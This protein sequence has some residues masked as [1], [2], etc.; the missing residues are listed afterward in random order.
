MFELLL[1]AVNA[2]Q[3]VVYYVFLLSWKT[4]KFLTT[5]GK[6][7]L[8]CLSAALHYL[9][10]TMMVFLEDF[11]P[12]ASDILRYLQATVE[13]LS[14]FKNGLF[15]IFY[16][17]HSILSTIVNGLVLSIVQ[18]F[19]EVI[20]VVFSVLNGIIEVF[21]FIKR[22]LILFGAGVWFLLT[23]IPLFVVSC[24]IYS[25]YCVGLLIEE[26]KNIITK[27][28]NKLTHI[29][30]FVT[31]VPLES[32]AGLL[33]AICLVYIFVKFHVEMYDF[34]RRKFKMFIIVA[35]RNIV[36]INWRFYKRNADEREEMVIEE[37][38]CIIC[39]ENVKDVL[40]LP[41]KHVCLCSYCQLKLNRH[42]RKCPVCR[43]NVQRT[44]KVFI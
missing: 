3:I 14:F 13:V 43:T 40:L 39:Q 18:A 44:M 37:N 26:I 6:S 25:T 28:A 24:F 23:L 36:S 2:V 5:A 34:F 31:D 33:V 15:S 42:G 11:H 17:I 16:S 27:F 12:F 4:G 1:S 9:F 21:V 19:T 38:Y 20:N 41:C 7:L 30:E 22:I 32:L 8:L 35:R 29:Y 10:D